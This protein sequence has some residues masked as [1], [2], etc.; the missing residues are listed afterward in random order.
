ML[1]RHVVGC[2]VLTDAVSLMGQGQQ[3]VGVI[4]SSL[5]NMTRPSYV[6]STRLREAFRLNSNSAL[7]THPV[8]EQP[9]APRPYEPCSDASSDRLTSPRKPFTRWLMQLSQVQTTSGAWLIRT[10]QLSC[11][12]A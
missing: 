4:S 7:S 5:V 2:G 1:D 3:L 8:S 11:S 9:N 6:C 10:S 12:G